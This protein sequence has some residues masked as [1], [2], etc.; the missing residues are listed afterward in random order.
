MGHK[1]LYITIIVFALP[2]SLLAQD[3]MQIGKGK[4]FTYSGSLAANS[5]FSSDGSGRD[6]FSYYFSGSLNL[7]LYGI[8]SPL[9]FNYSNHKFGY[10]QPFKFNRLKMSPSY[11]WVRAYVGD[12]SMSFSPYSLNGCQFTGGGVE[13]TPNG[14]WELSL[15]AGQ[16]AKAVEYNPNEKRTVPAYRR[17]GFGARVGFKKSNYKLGFSLFKARDQPGSI[18][19][20]GPAELNVV[21]KENLVLVFSGMLDFMEN[22]N[23]T[24]ECA[25]S[26][27][28]RNLNSG[29]DPG[30]K[31]NLLGYLF[32]QQASTQYFS[33][34][35]MNINFRHGNVTAGLG[36]ERVDPGYQTLGAYYMNN[37]LENGALNLGLMLFKGKLN[38]QASGGLQRNN[39]NNTAESE[40][41]RTVTSLSANF[42]PGEKLN[43]SL[44][45]SNFQS[46]LHIKNQFDYINATS[47]YQNLDT[48]HFT[49]ITQNVALNVM[50]MPRSDKKVQNSIS[51]MA[52]AMDAADKQGQVVLKGNA[53]RFYNGYL[54][55]SH[56]FVPH[57]L[58]FD[59]SVNASYNT[60]GGQRTMMV[61]PVLSVQKAMLKNKL[62]AALAFA[63][64]LGRARNLPDNN[65]AN[66]RLNGNYALGKKHT[67]NLCGTYQTVTTEGSP[68]R[69]TLSLIAG[70]NFVFGGK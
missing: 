65:T 41:L 27:L 37:D 69:N 49:Q 64:N 8:S 60:I 43:V 55:Y 4:A 32:H 62:Q 14:P 36:Y 45:Y 58:S 29:N 17:V 16:F 38:V 70:Y 50:Y 56:R 10:A 15:M 47:P 54:G 13:L 21:P 3:L 63:Y 30:K 46:Y 6:P 19:N 11:K 39:L 34:Y 57:N 12:A 67:F 24:W 48:L 31:R 5:V 52:S 2:V 28:N 66:L 33:A 53:S 20:P 26:G 68:G 22:M 59:G 35:K 25:T 7:A 9:S 61:G 18:S 51:F 40:M 44:N 42:K 1:Y 23:F